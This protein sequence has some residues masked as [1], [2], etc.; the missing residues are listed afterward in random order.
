MSKNTLV[1]GLFT[2]LI[3]FLIAAP[4]FAQNYT[5]AETKSVEKS[6]VLYNKG[7]YDKAIS[8]ITKVQM[9][10]IYDEELWTLRIIYEN[11]RYNVQFSKDIAGLI[12]KAGKS[13]TVN[14]DFD[15]LK[16]TQYRGELLV[17]C[18]MATNYANNQIL[19]SSILHDMIIEPTVDT[20]ISDDAKELR[21]KGDEEYSKQNYTAAIRQYQ[22]AIDEEPNYYSA[23]LD[24]GFCYYKDEKWDK[25]VTWF[26]K[27]SALQPEMLTP[28]YYMI[29][30]LKSDKKWDEVY[31]A[32]IEAIIQYPHVGYFT[33]LEEACDKKDKT[34]K[35][36]WMSRDYFPNMMSVTSQ[37]TP[38]EEPWNFYRNAKDKLY[39]YCDDDGVVTKS[40]TVTEQ[41]YLEVYSWEYMLK[42][43]DTEDKEIGFARKM[44][45]QG[46]LDCFA[47]VS[48]FHI[49]F[50]NQYKAFRDAEGNRARIKTYI[51]TQLIK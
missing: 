27:A 51:E 24:I 32:C 12:K 16:S 6:K 8:T 19:A 46:Y 9:A 37:S 20:T 50:W 31:S 18:Y 35:R 22:K 49:S 5:A 33:S 41:K 28:R 17:A 44:Q 26:A 11:T 36:H 13:G 2:A 4:A 47:M 25:A 48:M 3:A 29:E 30:C 15:K 38:D 45:E 42:K 7:K 1:K 23:T 21:S 43:S 39:D 14:V 10:H 40:Q 34:F